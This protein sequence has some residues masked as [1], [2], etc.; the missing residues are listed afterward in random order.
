MGQPQVLI[1]SVVGILMK[2]LLALLVIGSH[3]FGAEDPKS[4]VQEFYQAISAKDANSAAGYMLT[5]G[6]Y[7]KDANTARVQGWIDRKTKI[8]E[9]K[10]SK[11]AEHAAVV[12][13]YESST[14]P[15]PMYLYKKEEKWLILPKIT[16]YATKDAEWPDDVRAEYMA[17]QNWYETTVGKK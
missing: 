4:V 16:S 11:S 12:I 17:L 3:V 2:T 13:I 10:D 8:P 1:K 5:T 9:I 7:T 15:D 14:D 6:R